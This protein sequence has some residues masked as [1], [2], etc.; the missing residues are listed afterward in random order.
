MIEEEKLAENSDKLG[1]LVREELLAKLNS[2]LVVNIR[3]KGLLN[4]IIIDENKGQCYNWHRIFS[5]YLC[6]MV[7]TWVNFGKLQLTPKLFHQYLHV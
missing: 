4:A 6:Y 3:G 7:M 1:R 2:E 5:K